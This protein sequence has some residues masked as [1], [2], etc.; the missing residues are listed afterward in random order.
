MAKP[1]RALIGLSK[2]T[3]ASIVPFVEFILVSLTGNAFFPSP[4]PVLET[5][6]DVLTDYKAALIEAG[7]RD[8]NKIAVKNQLR[9]Q[10]NDLV[11]QLGYYVNNIANGDYTMIVSSGFPVSKQP[12]P[13]VVAVP[14]APVIMP[15]KNPGTL[16]SKVKACSGATG[17]VHYLTQAPLTE[18]SE[19]L[20]SATTR[21]VFEFT[22]LQPGTQ[23]I[24]KVA[25]I[26]SN[27]QVVFSI[28]VSQFAL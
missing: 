24:A 1:F 17:Y 23:Y 15:G 7:S 8:R 21:T 18:N 20:T 16:V 27:N 11:K 9:A 5:V 13:R 22:N 4:F 10:L 14:D 3:D 12:E 2:F 26:G 28:T 25:A 19:W 6:Q